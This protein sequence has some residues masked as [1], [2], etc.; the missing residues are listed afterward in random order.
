MHKQLLVIFSTMLIVFSLTL[1]GGG[2]TY[3]FLISPDMQA[4]K[5]IQAGLFWAGAL[6]GLFGMAGF[7]AGLVGIMSAIL[8]KIAERKE[9]LAVNREQEML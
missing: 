2:G 7:L 3:M 8:L 9:P 4:D 1:I 6:I 5:Y